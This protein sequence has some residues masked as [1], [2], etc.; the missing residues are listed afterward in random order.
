MVD[1]KLSQGALS[2]ASPLESMLATRPDSLRVRPNARLENSEPRSLWWIR[3]GSGLRRTTA[4]A[5]YLAV[6]RV[7]LH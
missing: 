2:S 7:G 3:P 6:N 5:G 4:D 1:I